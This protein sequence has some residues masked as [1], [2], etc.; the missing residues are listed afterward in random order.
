[1]ICCERGFHGLGLVFRE[2]PVR[3]SAEDG[4]IWDEDG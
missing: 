3:P 1:M 2:D 4:F